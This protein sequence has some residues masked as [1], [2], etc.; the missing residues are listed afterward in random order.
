MVVAAVGLSAITFGACE[1]DSERGDCV[2][3][4]RYEGVMYRYDDFVDQS[5]PSGRD[6]G[7]GEV[8]DCGTLENAPVVAEVTVTS[9]RGVDPSVAVKVERGYG[10]GVYVAENVPSDDWPDG[11]TASPTR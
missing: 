7:G 8:V 2:A 4:I 11:L 3:R 5:A 1:E 10:S 9:V 6:L